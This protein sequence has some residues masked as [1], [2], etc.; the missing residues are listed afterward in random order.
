MKGKHHI[1][2]ESARLKYE[3]DIKRNITIIQGDSATGKTTLIELIS[4][5]QNS[6]ENSPVRIESDVPC[7]VF[8]GI[9]DRW[10]AMLELISDSIIFI[11]EGNY[12]IRQKEFAEVVQTSSN[13]FVLI[14]RENLPILPYSIQEIYGI[15]T[16]GKYHF[17][18]KVYHEFYPIYSEIKD[19]AAENEFNMKMITED[20]D[21]G[22][23]FFSSF[24][25]NPENCISAGGNGN[26]YRAMKRVAE[27][28]LISVV[29][30]GA[31]F[32]PYI[33]RVLEYA[34]QRGK[35]LLYFPESFEWIILESGVITERDLEKI[36][37]HPEDYID[38]KDYM[39]W[40]QFFAE[41]LSE[42]TRDDAVKQYRKGSLASYYLSVG[43]RAKIM[44]V[45]PDKLRNMLEPEDKQTQN[46]I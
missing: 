10:S 35:V 29:A 22:N 16:S 2:I 40:E 46:S 6:R 31:A 17:P 21:S 42:I 39:S 1:V 23:Q 5:Y 38:S 20:S 18:E 30:D 33:A 45:L 19:T 3:F 9:G 28:T 15:R 8:G 43:I 34:E 26:I 25:K 32:G 37:K 13:Y 14:T 4:D 11:D 7:E 12:F 44:Q 41:K 36:L 24:F 27:D